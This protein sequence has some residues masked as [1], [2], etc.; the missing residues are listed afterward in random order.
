MSDRLKFR[1]WDGKQMLTMPL[2]GYFGIER[3]FGILHDKWEVMQSTGQKDKNDV[4]SFEG[5][6]I[7]GTYKKVCE[8]V[9]KNSPI[10]FSEGCFWVTCT[11][12]WPH[13]LYELSEK[14]EIIGNIH[15]DKHLLEVKE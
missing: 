14:F 1:A 15:Q 7:N 10:H 9:F 6:L 8:V 3:F 12:G 11:N 2:D 5:D 4:L 13:P